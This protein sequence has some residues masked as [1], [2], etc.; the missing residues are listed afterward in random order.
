M[1]NAKYIVKFPV[2][3]FQHLSVFDS[4]VHPKDTKLHTVCNMEVKGKTEAGLTAS[5]KNHSQVKPVFTIILFRVFFVS[6]P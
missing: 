1:Y 4:S 6:W 5:G 2:L 3:S